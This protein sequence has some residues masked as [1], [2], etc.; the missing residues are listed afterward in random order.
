LEEHFT[1][2]FRVEEICGLTSSALFGVVPEDAMEWV[3]RGGRRKER[4]GIML[5]R[6]NKRNG[7]VE[8]WEKRIGK[9]V[10]ETYRE[11]RKWVWG[12]WDSVGSCS[13]DHT[14]FL[15]VTR[16]G[17]VDIYRCLRE[18]HCPILRPKV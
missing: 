8:D 6:E 18:V 3:Q 16:C 4:K 1:S 13:K 5:R 2:I 11:I 9:R 12:V 15:H 7:Q 14:V 10:R 17:L